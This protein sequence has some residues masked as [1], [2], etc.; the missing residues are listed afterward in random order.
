EK[1]G[2]IKDS[3]L[4]EQSNKQ[5][6]QLKI[7]YETDK[8]DQQI[9]TQELQN[10]IL[11]TRIYYGIAI[12]L[13]VI[14]I[15]GLLFYLSYLRNRRKKREYEHTLTDLELT[16]L[17]SQFNPHFISNSLINIKEFIEQQPEAVDQFLTKFARLMRKVLEQNEK[18]LT[19]LKEELET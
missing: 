7:Q 5:I 15:I 19:S 9:K 8:K 6:S 13:M 4:N 2:D 12:S 10:R 11:R 18:Q 3:I 16:V 1:Y 14:G 17:K